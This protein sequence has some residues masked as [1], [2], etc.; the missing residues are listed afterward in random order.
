[1]SWVDPVDCDI[2]DPDHL[3]PSDSRLLLFVP[4]F[5]TIVNDR[6]HSFGWRSFIIMKVLKKMPFL[7]EL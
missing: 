3:R 4:D 6:F 2:C 1:M 5:K 7:G